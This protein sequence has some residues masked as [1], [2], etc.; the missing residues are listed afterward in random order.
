MVF[1]HSSVFYSKSIQ[2]VPAPVIL[3]KLGENVL[4]LFRFYL[5]QILQQIGKV[6]VRPSA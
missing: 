6:T 1:C 3:R 5:F 4:Y 2:R